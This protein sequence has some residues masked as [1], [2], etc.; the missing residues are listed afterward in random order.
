MERLDNSARIWI[1]LIGLI[2]VVGMVLLGSRLLNGDNSLLRNVSVDD[3]Q[4]TPNADGELDVTN[5]QYELSRD[6]N[7]SIYFEN[8]AGD[9]FYFRQDNLRDSGLYEVQFS[10]VVDGYALPDDLVQ[11]EILTRLLQDGLYTWTVEATDKEGITETQQ[12]QLEII[13]ADTTL[14]D[15]RNFTIDRDVF[16]PNQD[17]ISD[18]ALIQFD[19]AKDVE[20]LRVFLQM[21]D[22]VEMPISER[23]RGVPPL[24]EGRH[25]FD[26]EAG[27]DNKATPPPDGTYPII[28]IARDLEGQQVRVEDSLTIR[29]GGV[30]Y[31]KI[32][33]PPIGDTVAWNE[34]AVGL[35]DTLTFTVTVEN[36]GNTPIRTTGP[37]PSTVYDSSWNYNTLGWETESGAWRIGIGYENELKDYGYR[38]AIGNLEDLELIDGHYYLMPNTRSVVTGSIRIVDFLGERNPQ[39]VWAGLIHEDVEI[40]QFN[41]RVDPQA[42]TLDFPDEENMFTCEERDIPR[43]EE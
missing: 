5:I 12:G 16:T 20:T 1:A 37:F 17:G 39:P 30:P 21:P 14:P 40:S 22:G 38:W 10:G 9:R 15:M 35:C 18:R 31:A 42:I 8:P 41:T 29:F 34:T 32:V 28:A 4:I 33:S 24:Q 36:Y 27:V 2:I 13:D 23:E 7:I 11:G 43:R 19:L 3:T 6:A 26:Y 25:E